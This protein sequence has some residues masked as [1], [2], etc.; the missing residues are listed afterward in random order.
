M[1]YTPY[2]LRWM[3]FVLWPDVHGRP[4]QQYVKEAKATQLEVAEAL[5]ILLFANDAKYFKDIELS[6]V[7]GNEEIV[8]SIEKRQAKESGSV[9]AKSGY[10]R[11]REDKK[12]SNLSVR[13]YFNQ[14]ASNYARREPPECWCLSSTQRRR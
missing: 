2:Q 12:R 5:S 11:D 10:L 8:R 7:F 6:D 4:V 14:V 9:K 13:A 3:L 1:A